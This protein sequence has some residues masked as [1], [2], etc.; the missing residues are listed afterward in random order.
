[1][2]EGFGDEY[3]ER[4]REE[5]ESPR[6]GRRSGWGDDEPEYETKHLYLDEELEEIE[7]ERGWPIEELLEGD[8]LEIVEDFTGIRACSAE[9]VP[10]WDCIDYEVQ[11]A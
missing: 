9:W 2:Y 1:M 5:K 8:L 7:E 11:V 10:G 4:V 3:W 6:A